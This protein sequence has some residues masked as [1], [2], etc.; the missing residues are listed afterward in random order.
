MAAAEIRPLRPKQPTHN[1]GSQFHVPF[2]FGSF[3]GTPPE[4]ADV[5][6]KEG[7]TKTWI[8]RETV[9]L[10]PRNSDQRWVNNKIVNAEKDTLRSNSHRA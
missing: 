2:P 4:V 10:T 9:Q 8:A 7:E 1:P 5:V 6:E 3:H